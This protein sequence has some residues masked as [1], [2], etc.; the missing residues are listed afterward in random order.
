MFVVHACTNFLF[1][2]NSPRLLTERHRHFI[3]FNEKL[4]KLMEFFHIH[5]VYSTFFSV[6]VGYN[7]FFQIT[8]GLAT[9]FWWMFLRLLW[10]FLLLRSTLE[11]KSICWW[12]LWT[13]G[14]TYKDNH[15]K[16]RRIIGILCNKNSDRFLEALLLLRTGYTLWHREIIQ[17]IYLYIFKKSWK[18]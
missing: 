17:Y 14:M 3:Q 9:S 13:K 1:L 16:W 12:L 7:S 2:I 11:A 15:V 6:K 18:E 4:T 10:T 5:D 8:I